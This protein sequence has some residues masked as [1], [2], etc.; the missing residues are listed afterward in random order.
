MKTLVLLS[1]LALCLGTAHAQT[2]AKSCSSCHS[3]ATCAQQTGY[4]TCSCSSGYAGDGISCTPISS[5]TTATCCSQG[6]TWDNRAG[7]KVCTDVNE[8]LDTTLNNCVPS[9]TC[10]NKVGIY[11]CSSSRTVGCPNNTCAFDQDCLSNGTAIQCADPCTNYMILNGS[12][13]LSTINSTGVFSTDRYNFGWFRYNGTTG[14]RMQQGCVGALKCGSAEPYTLNGSH[15][16]IGQGV[17][18]M[19][20]LSNTV[21]GCTAAGT[22]PVKA[23]P[24]G[25]YVY[26][27]TGSLQTEVY[28]TDPAGF[29]VPT[30]PPTTTIP[31]TTTTPTTTTRPTTTTTPTTTTPTTTTRPTTTT[32]PTTTTPTTTTRPTTTTTP[33][34]TTRP[35][36]TTTPT[37]TTPTTTTRPTTTTT[38]T[39]TT[40][41][42]TTRPTTT[43][44]PTTTTP[45]T[46]TRPTTTTQPTTTPL[47]TTTSPQ[48]NITVITLRTSKVI[49]FISTVSQMNS[50]GSTNIALNETTTIYTAVQTISPLSIRTSINITVLPSYT[51]TT[52]GNG[53]PVTF[54]NTP[55]PQ[56]SSNDTTVANLQAFQPSMYV[57]VLPHTTTLT[58]TSTVNNNNVTSTTT[59][60]TITTEETVVKV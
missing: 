3:A 39:T 10:I 59:T 9:S 12:T 28:C 46:T 55:T 17:V 15:P 44:T 6:Y 16:A 53:N 35:T 51:S 20:L 26:K 36:T 32:T 33:T 38:P 41:T 8:C 22:I 43:T 49:S 11:L 60:T 21:T 54:T 31:T 24:G 19:N 1:Y 27:F 42:T 23:C 25:F 48:Q 52:I 37:T 29:V 47:A 57:N 50:T 30:M 40:P 58:E 18:M 14:L 7:Y 13:R 34:T 5:C 2:N 45:T 56:V 4:V